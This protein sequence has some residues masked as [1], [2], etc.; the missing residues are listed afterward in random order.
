MSWL[1]WAF[2]DRVLWLSEETSAEKGQAEHQ[3][4]ALVGLGF[5]LSFEI[6]KLFISDTATGMRP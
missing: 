5:V 4:T 3:Q 6:A 2:R 1:V